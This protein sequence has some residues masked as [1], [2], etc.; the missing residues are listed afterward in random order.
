MQQ[1]YAN[2]RKYIAVLENIGTTLMKVN[3][4]YNV[5]VVRT[6][7]EKVF[8]RVREVK[9]TYAGCQGMGINVGTKEVEID[10]DFMQIAEALVGRREDI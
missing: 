1:G 7:V 2:V 8:K 9:M 4:S 10:Q 5:V 3:I 6:I